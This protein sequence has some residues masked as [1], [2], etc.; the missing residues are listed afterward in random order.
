MKKYCK[1]Q[2]ELAN[3]LNTTIDLY[4]SGNLSENQLENHL[5]LLCTSNIEK[6]LKNDSI[7]KIVEQRCGKKRLELL[8]KVISLSGL[9]KE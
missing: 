6:L 4:W 8:G 2:S 1:N 5:S 7:T 3:E 9:N